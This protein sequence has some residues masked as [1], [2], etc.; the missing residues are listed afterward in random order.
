VFTGARYDLSQALTPCLAARRLDSDQDEHDRLQPVMA[1]LFRAIIARIADPEVR[2][3]LA[4]FIVAADLK[5]YKIVLNDAAASLPWPDNS[6]ARSAF[7]LE[8]LRQADD[9]PRAVALLVHHLAGPV[10]PDDLDS[11]LAMI[12]AERAD[13]RRPLAQIIADLTQ[14]LPI[15]TLDH[16]W[17]AA[18]RVPEL[19]RALADWYR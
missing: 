7:V 6:A 17:E 5:I 11:Y 10:R 14:S 19:N 13:L 1:K 18:S 15:N 4:A 12:L 3:A 8:T 9:P 16:V 2:K